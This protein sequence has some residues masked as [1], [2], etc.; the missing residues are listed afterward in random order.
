MVDKTVYS[1]I[2]D[3]A[4][5]LKEPRKYGDVSLMIGAGFSKNAQSKGGASI[6]PPNWSELAVKMYEE[7]YPEPVEEEEK[8]EWSK[9]K[10]IKTSGKNVTKL[11]EEY[12][13]NFDR[14]KINN[15]IEQS[16]ADEMFVPGELH[17]RLL[18]LRWADVFTTN[19]DTL[20]EQT[21]DMIYRENNYEII[22]SQNDLPG[23][24][25]PR[26]IKLHGSI[27]QVKPYIICDEDYRTYPDKYSA[28]VNTVQQAMLETRL[29]L[30]GFSGDDPN[31]QS[32]LGWLRDNMGEYCPQIYLIGIYD[33]L[34]APERKLLDN[35][36]ITIVDISI[37][38]SEQNVDRHYKAIS[39]FLS[40]LEKYQN[41]K[42]VYVDGPYSK[43]DGFWEPKKEEVGEY[44][45]KL[46]EYACKIETSIRPYILLPE[47]KREKY[48]KY[49]SK[50]FN[51]ILKIVKDEIPCK[52]L[53]NII[54][55]LKKC[56]VILDDENAE[57]L[58]KIRKIL[59]EKNWNVETLCEILL[60]LAEMYRIDGKREQYE[61]CKKSCAA[62]CGNIPY[63]RNE[64]LV[65]TIKNHI[66]LFDYEEAKTLIEQIE[67]ST[68]EYKIKKAAFYKQLSQNDIADKI[69]SECS[70]ELAQMKLS[71]EVYAAYLGYL[72]LCYRAGNWKITEEYSDNNQYNNPYNT[73]RIIVEQRKKLEQIFFEKDRKKE[74][75][76]VPFSLN[77]NKSITVVL[78]GENV[79]YLE[80]F[81]FI[82]GIDR[83]CLPIFS[84]QAKLLPRVNDEIMHSSEKV[85]WKMALAARTDQEK[86]INQ[87][88][89][90]KT[91]LNIN[92]S[93]KEYLFE[94]LIK[95]VKLYSEKDRYDRKKFYMSVKNI[96]NILSRLV[97]FMEDEN[98]IIFL[99]ILSRF[100][101]RYDSHIAVDINKILQIISTRFNG[102]IAHTCQNILFLGFH[103]RYH[104]ASYFTD[105]SFEILEDNVER[106]Y[107]KSLQLSS[108]EDTSERDNGLS[109]LLVLWKNKPLEKYRDKIIATFW[110]NDKKTLP[111]SELYY[112][113]IWEVLPH[114]QEVDFS[115]IYYTYLMDTKYIESVTP[116]GF[117][118]NDSYGSIRNY[119]GF[120][121]SVSEIS[122]RQCNKVVLDK[123]LAQMIL[124]RSYE[125]IIHEKKLLEY[126]FMGEK[127]KC[128]KKFLMLSELVALVYCESLQNHLIAEIYPIVEKIKK[129]LENCK[130]N[131]IAIDMVEMVEKNEL[132]KCVDTFE[133]IILTKNKRD[134][135]GAFIGIQ[136]LVFINKDGNQEISFENFFAAIKYLDIEYAKTLWI[137]LTQLLRQPFFGDEVVQ[138]YI[139]S[140]ISKC[141]DIYEELANKGE[142]YYLDGLYN[143]SQ[144]LHQ[145]H[146]CINMA[147][148]IE[149]D[150]LKKCVEK[151]MRIEN[152][153]IANIWVC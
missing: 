79:C 7:L 71:D 119:C 93:E 34:S 88:F 121:Y 55:I 127:D 4:Q 3:I 72:N 98:L 19:Y 148:K 89:T 28:L 49:F 139:A 50:H 52:L 116:T 59:E 100:S 122:L 125:F 63:Y 32:W 9:Q 96:L 77:S 117:V 58:E 108:S 142:R 57:K 83:L 109:C 17:K 113:F 36:G 43:V 130:I 23:S 82:L 10:I 150:E 133:N 2:N 135:S 118:G 136:C 53:T 54:K 31:F 97:V 151:A 62:Y 60:Y 18:K 69:L 145:Y 6:Q 41:E 94:M 137:Q 90:R 132:E 5:R 128:E 140:S 134:Y 107:T 80:S 114:P 126:D 95:V 68:F 138:K 46:E 48:T 76:I 13:A 143:C 38:V 11:A 78:G 42:D 147:G 105:I 47:E 84:D 8:R 91:I 56:L 141:I 64:F 106:F 24:I 45:K 92:E 14:N 20:L 153:E 27:P 110:E 61:A 86:V 81:V 37:L 15:L 51:I 124:T 101:Q 144:A 30:L 16:V 120:F 102:N 112:P 75:S 35:K 67:T 104:I 66:S 146:T 21:A 115:S 85:Y 103:E 33:T 152:Y 129:E 111:T 29:C 40:L 87:I 22:Y 123:E 1:Y 26:I 44:F 131:T 74:E 25:K 149:V 73:R 12:I 65:E 70:A 39:E 99:K